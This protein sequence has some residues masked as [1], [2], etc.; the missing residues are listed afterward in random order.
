MKLKYAQDLLQESFQN[1]ESHHQFGPMPP[2]LCPFS[3][4]MR[5]SPDEALTPHPILKSQYGFLLDEGLVWL[6]DQSQAVSIEPIP[7]VVLRGMR[8]LIRII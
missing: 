5:H 6:L 2:T 1:T 8:R 4:R 3:S 7:R